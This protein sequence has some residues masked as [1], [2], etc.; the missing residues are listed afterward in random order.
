MA[1]IGSTGFTDA[2]QAALYFARKRRRARLNTGPVIVL[3]N[4]SIAEDA[5]VGDT[6]GTLSVTGGSGT[7]TFTLTGDAGGKFALDGDDVEVADALDYDVATF[8]TIE[9]EADNGVDPVIVQTIRINVLNIGATSLTLTELTDG[10]IYQRAIG[11]TDKDITIS[12][13]YA[14]SPVAIEVRIFDPADDSDIVAWQTLDASP[15]AGAF[16]GTVTVPQG[17]PHGYEVRDSTDTDVGAVGESEFFVGALIIGYGQSNMGGMFDV[18]SSPPAANAITRYFD[19]SDWVS[20]PSGN[21]IRELLNELAT[22]T[23]IPWGAIDGSAPGVGISF[24]VEG[25]DAF[26]ALASQI[27]A[28]GDAEFIVW[29][30][31]EGNTSGG[32]IAVETYITSLAGL[33]DSI[34]DEV[35]RTT[36]EIPLL[37]ASLATHTSGVN[38]DQGW[39]N[40][41]AALRK[42]ALDYADI[43]YSHSNMDA[44]LSDG[45]HWTAAGYANAGKRYAQTILRV[46]GDETDDPAWFIDAAEIVDATHTDITVVHSMGTDFSP[47]SG[48][49]GFEISDDNGANWEV[50]SAAARQDATTIRLTH[51]SFSLS[52]DRLVRYQFGEA[53]DVSDPVVDNG[54]LASPLN[55]TANQVISAEGSAALPVPTFLSMAALSHQGSN[56]YRASSYGIGAADANR[57]IIFCICGSNGTGQNITGVTIGGVTAT[58]IYDN[59]PEGTGN[60]NAWY[61]AIV[62]TGTT[63]TIDVQFGGA[64]FFAPNVVAWSVDDTTLLSPTPVDADEL[65]STSF[66]ST[67]TSLNISS[68]AGGFI[69]AVAAKGT[70]TGGTLDISGDETLV[71]RLG[72]TGTDISGGRV[73]AADASGVAAGTNDNTVTLTLGA[74]GYRLGF[75]ALSFR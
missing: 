3:S 20:V 26:T 8:H 23:G 60:V 5:G 33:H 56:L 16:S 48:I 58:E 40:V 73:Q 41:Q 44:P 57:R 74:T 29:H 47:S 12:G 21:G 1:K 6:V 19:G 46:L 38:G 65:S 9:V 66:G 13:T 17:G 67:S 31:G 72:T 43:H 52:D 59:T 32:G 24:L 28:I 51:S 14:G 11:G 71:E 7:Y 18:S 37:T 54:A 55:H 34:A 2:Q 4:R 39:F 22:E 53:P 61:T 27:A 64:I 35:G 30:H 69:L 68:T 42:A 25:S 75:V 70:T 50:P 62:P 49:T 36:A 45:L 63:A 15:S 10:R